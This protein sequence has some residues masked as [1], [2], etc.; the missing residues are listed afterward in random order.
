[1]TE[2]LYSNSDTPAQSNP[3]D[4]SVFGDLNHLQ[5]LMSGLD[6]RG[7]A[8]ALAAFAEDSLGTLLKS[9]LV[10]S[11]ATSRLIDGFN[12]PLG[13]F[14]A[15]IKAAYGLGLI[16]KNQF[17][18]LERLRKIRNYFSH[19][20]KPA[21][22]NDEEVYKLIKEL[23]FSRL[24]YKYPE[25]LTSKLRES[26]HCLLLEIHVTESQINKNNKRLKTIGSDILPL[27]SGSPLEKFTRIRDIYYNLTK[28]LGTAKD[29]KKRFCEDQL[30]ALKVVFGLGYY[31]ESEF[32]NIVH[33]KDDKLLELLK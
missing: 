13:T 1:M 22:I 4:D 19:T 16:N 5:N 29:D 17:S 15:R 7:L 9:F 24:S 3:E 8:I 11:D 18:D 6:D 14:S 32:A 20:W 10:Q 28:E 27:I 26:G 31:R 12:A 33:E 23:N 30:S 25:N 21:S 2:Y